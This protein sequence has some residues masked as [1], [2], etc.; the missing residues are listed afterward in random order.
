MEVNVSRGGTR[1]TALRWEIRGLLLVTLAVV[2]CGQGTTSVSGIVMF[3][4][5]PLPSG[6]V[7]FHGPDGRIQ[8]SLISEDGSYAM[9]DA[10]L[11]QVRITVQ[12]HPAAPAGL[13]SRGGKPPATPTELAPPAKAKPNDRAVR[14][15]PRYLDPEKS[16]LT[17]TVR[18]GAQRHDLTLQP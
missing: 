8:H 6:T 14:I 18:A 11:G 15:P 1:P 9:V 4:D 3:K 13:P 16:G 7:L 10:P 2:G 12:S 17:Y 5:Q